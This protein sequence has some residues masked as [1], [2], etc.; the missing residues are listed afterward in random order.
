MQS[1]CC[2]ESS[3]D[4]AAEDEQR[5]MQLACGPGVLEAD[6][7]HH[8]QYA[9]QHSSKIGRCCVQKLIQEDHEGPFRGSGFRV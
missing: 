9:G 6:E 4:C 1:R 5:P 2:L 7:M 3:N 8:S